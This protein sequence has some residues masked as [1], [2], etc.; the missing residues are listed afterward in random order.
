MNSRSQSSP[1]AGEEVRADRPRLWAEFIDPADADRRLR[2]DLTWLTSS[3]R[4][5]FGQG[6]PGVY[7]ERPDDGCCTLGAHFSDVDDLARVAAV[8]TD[9]GPDEWQMFDY[10]QGQDWQRSEASPDPEMPAEV[11][12]TLVEGACVFLNRP[13]FPAGAGC[14]LHQ[15]ALATGQQ[16][17]AT[18]PDVCWQLPIHRS[19][20]QVH[21]ADETDYTEVTI[22]EYGRGE[23]GP[24][25]HDFHW[26]CTAA[27]SAHTA[28]VPVYL[29]L[30]SELTELIGESAYAE[31]LRV[32]E[33][34]LPPKAP[35]APVRALL[36]LFVH[37]ATSAVVATAASASPPA[38]T[39]AS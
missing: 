23:W 35:P 17:L 21:R 39:G 28:H 10:G 2:V 16:P 14:A 24:G 22:T 30:A 9:L 31:L 38:T 18:K 27:P 34:A 11:A 1:V 15:H 12:T 6:C 19:F 33:G 3:W 36:P 29:S 20:R 26:Y 7:A 25:G 32:C 4:C 5:L 13:G 37:P 8:V